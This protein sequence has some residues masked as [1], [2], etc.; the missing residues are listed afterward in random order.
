MNLIQQSDL[1]LEQAEEY[2]QTALRYRTQA[3]PKAAISGQTKDHQGLAA[4]LRIHF[5]FP[6]LSDWQ[7]EWLLVLYWQRQAL[8]RLVNTPQRGLP[9][10]LRSRVERSTRQIEHC[11]M[12]MVAQIRN[13]TSAVAMS[14][15]QLAL[16]DREFLRIPFPE[17]LERGPAPINPTPPDLNPD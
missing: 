3:D 16:L 9:P 5:L 14:P 7:T 10:L 2:V 8:T 4:H 11:F 17:P 13:L 12:A 6:Q 1:L 15:V